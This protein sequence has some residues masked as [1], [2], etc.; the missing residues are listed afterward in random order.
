MRRKG[1]EKYWWGLLVFLLFTGYMLASFYWIEPA[2]QRFSW[3]QAVSRVLSVLMLGGWLAL[4]WPAGRLSAGRVLRAQLICGIYPFVGLLTMEFFAGAAYQN[5]D[6]LFFIAVSPWQGVMGLFP[7]FPNW[8][9]W[10]FCI[11]VPLL[12][13]VL[14]RLGRRRGIS[15]GLM[16]YRPSSLQWPSQGDQGK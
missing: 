13:A 9:T 7:R 11:A 5:L 2:L 8:A 3:G 16:P 15:S 4:S 14:Y 1:E 12:Q 10:L 6:L